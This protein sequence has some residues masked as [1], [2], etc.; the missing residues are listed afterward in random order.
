MTLL[1]IAFPSIILAQTGSGLSGLNGYNGFSFNGVDD[2][3]LSGTA[4]ASGDINGDGID[5]LVIGAPEALGSSNDTGEVYVIFG[6][7]NE[8]FGADLFA[9]SLNGS[10]GYEIRG[11]N[12]GDYTGRSVTTGDIDGD[13]QDD[14]IIGASSADVGTVSSAGKTY[15]IYAASLSVLDAEDGA[16]GI[17]SLSNFSSTHGYV[18]NGEG[19]SDQAGISVA[20]GDVDGDG[21][22]DIIVGAFQSIMVIPEMG[23]PMWYSVNSCLP[24]MVMQT[25]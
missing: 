9:S 12:D 13:G 5:D 4:L 6:R 24:L 11:V 16:D 19:T 23:R 8:S 17:I 25:G 3:A 10:N 14:L 2:A 15:V 7:Q 1:I 20:S 18:L 21:K 22:D